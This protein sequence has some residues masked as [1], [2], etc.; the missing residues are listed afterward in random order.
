MQDLFNNIKNSILQFTLLDLFDIL[1]VAAL[2]YG[3][4]KVTS[5]TRA[6][7]V[8]KGLGLIIVAAQVCELI[9]LTG[10][11]WLL[12]YVINAGAVLLVIL[13]QPEIRRALEK[14][15]RGRV[16]DLSVGS[17]VSDMTAELEEVERAILDMSIRK[18]GALMVF[19]KKTGL[20]EVIETGTILEAQISAQLIENVFFPNSPLHDGAMIIK[21][22]RIVAAGC[23]LPL[24]D[25]K[26]IS[27][28]LG[29]RHRA[30]LGVSE[31]SDSIVLIVS[32]ETGVISV[33]HEGTITRYIDN[34]ALRRV[35]SDIFEGGQKS[36]SITA[37]IRKKVSRK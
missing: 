18:I 24:S 23:F 13:F 5:R 33:A 14:L 11:T 35:L 8:L 7:Q 9:G 10:I 2:I 29:T 30:A 26:Q 19:E 3:L 37:R 4:L 15:G 27:D 12:N 6:I 32:E 34:K 22:D 1:L 16:F 17:D 36:E 31:V 20:Q 28:E 21:K 25:N